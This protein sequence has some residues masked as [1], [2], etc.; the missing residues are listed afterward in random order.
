MRLILKCFVIFEKRTKNFRRCYDN[1]NANKY[2]IPKHIFFD[3]PA[4]ILL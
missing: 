2:L 3:F 4:S 1:V